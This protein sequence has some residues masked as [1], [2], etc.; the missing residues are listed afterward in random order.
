[1]SSA[2]L[3]GPIMPLGRLGEQALRLRRAWPDGV[4]PFRVELI[5]SDVEGFHLDLADLNALAIVAC[6][7]CALDL[8]TGLG[9]C[10]P[11]QFDHRQA[12]GERPAAPVLGNVT[13]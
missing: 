9:R 12:I 10:R 6:V 2:S 3:T 13:E 5:A 11:D 1:M 7:E 4:V 8:E